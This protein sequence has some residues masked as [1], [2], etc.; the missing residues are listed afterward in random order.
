MGKPL[1]PPPLL[2]TKI[3][4]LGA[5]S[6]IS[7]ERALIHTITNPFSS[8]LPENW[9]WSFLAIFH[10]LCLLMGNPLIS[11]SLILKKILWLGAVAMKSTTKKLLEAI[12]CPYS[13][14]FPE[15]CLFGYFLLF[16]TI[17]AC[18]GQALDPTSAFIDK[19]VITR[20]CY[21]D[22]Y[23]E[24][25]QAITTP[26]SHHLPENWIFGLFLTTFPHLCLLMGNP[27]TSYPLFLTKTLS[28]GALE[29]IPMERE[30]LQAIITPIPP[31]LWRDQ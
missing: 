6:T 19:Y 8:H 31:P 5:V 30:L 29:M 15:N 7:T 23:G 24:L 14:H 10:H 17:C 11:P 27:L 4:S 9:V 16:F 12:A 1:I 22:I 28:L 26:F 25:F 18:S 3:L 21:N 2:L 13:C 20:C